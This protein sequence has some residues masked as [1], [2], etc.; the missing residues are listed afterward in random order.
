MLEYYGKHLRRLD[1]KTKF[2]QCYDDLF[3]EIKT[4]NLETLVIHQ[5]SQD[6]WKNELWREEWADC[7][8]PWNSA[9]DYMILAKEVILEPQAWRECWEK[10]WYSQGGENIEPRT[11]S[12]V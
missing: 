11:S 3:D 2:P 1:F 9:L 7:Y 12:V 4:L 5:G 8:L 10:H 6:D